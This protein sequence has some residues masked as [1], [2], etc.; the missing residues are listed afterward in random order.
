MVITDCLSPVPKDLL[1][2]ASFIQAFVAQNAEVCAAA[3]ILTCEGHPDGAEGQLTKESE[4]PGYASIARPLPA[5]SA[6]G[7]PSLWR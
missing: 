2:R 4:Q 7:P 1:W 3:G 5:A 6:A